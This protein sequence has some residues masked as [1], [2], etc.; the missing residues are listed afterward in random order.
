MA[1]HFRKLIHAHRGSTHTFSG[2]HQQYRPRA[3]RKAASPES[4]FLWRGVGRL[5][6]SGVCGNLRL[7][8]RNKPRGRKSRAV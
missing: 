1:L 3:D 8:A 5:P 6:D 2:V 7:Q 4:P